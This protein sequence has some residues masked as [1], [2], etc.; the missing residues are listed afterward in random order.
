MTELREAGLT[1][2]KAARSRNQ[3]NVVAAADAVTTPFSNCHG[4][5]RDRTNR[6]PLTGALYGTGRVLACST[7]PSAVSQI[8]N[9]HAPFADLTE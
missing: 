1:A 4:H 2:Y 9:S 3:D 5:A 8:R 7:F 6:V